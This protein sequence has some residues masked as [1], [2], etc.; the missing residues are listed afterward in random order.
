MTS[1]DCERICWNDCSCA[2]YSSATKNGIGCKTYAK[3]IY[4][5]KEADQ[6]MRYFPIVHIGKKKRIWIVVVVIGSLAPLVWLS[7]YLVYKKLHVRGKGKKIQE[8]LLYQLRRFYNYVRTD[9]KM[10]TELHY[11]TFQSISSATNGFSTTNK[12]GEGGFGAVYKGKLAD[13]QEVAVKRLSRSS[14][15]GVKEFKNETELIAK[16][17]HVNLVRLIGC[18][19]EKQEKILVYEYMPN[20][21]LDF[22]LFDP[23]KKGLLN[24][25]SRFIIID[26]IA[27]GLLYLH[28]FSRLRVI[29]RDLKASNILLDDYL[30]PKISDFGMAKLFGIN[31]SQANTSRVVGTRG[32]MPPEYL[33]DGTISTKI[34]VFGFGV[35][36]IEIAWELW[37]EGRG[38]ELMDPVLEDSSTPKEV[39]TC[40]HVGLLC[41]QDSAADRPT[42]SE[43]I[44]M[45]TNGNMHLP[46]P[47]QPAFFIQRHD[48]ETHFSGEQVNQR[49]WVANRNNPIP[50]IYGK[51]MIDVH[52]EL[53]I[54][55][56]EATVLDLFS[57]D[58]LVIRN[59]SARLLDSGNFVLQELYPDGSAKRVLWQSFDY[60]T[61]TLLPGMKLGIN[62]KTGHRWSLTSWRSHELP[63][64]GS[65][66]L[67]VDSNNGTDQVVFLRRGNIYWKS[68]P[69][70]D[71]RFVNLNQSSDPDEHSYY[72]SNETEISFSYL[73]KTYN[74]FPYVRIY[75]D[76]MYSGKSGFKLKCQSV[77]DPPGCT[78]VE[79]EKLKC[80]KGYYISETY[81]Y[82]FEEEY[83]YDESYNLSLYDC[84]RICW[85][86]C[87]CVAYTYATRN[88]VGCKTY[89]K[90]RYNPAEADRDTK[91]FAIMFL[92]E[93]RKMWNRRKLIWLIIGIG[94]LAPALLSCYLVDKKLH[95][96]GKAMKIQKQ[97]LHQLTGFYNAVPT[98]MKMKSEVH[99]FTFQSISSA[100]DSFSS[101]NKLGEGGFGEVYKGILVDGQEVAVKRLSRNSGQG[102]KE[103][104]NEIEL[105]AKLQHT[106]LV[107]L[108]G[109]C[110]EKEEKI[111]VY[112]LMPNSSLDSFLFDPRK[113]GLLKWKKR[114]L[115]ID[116]IAQGLVYLHKFSRLRV[117]HRDLKANNILL[118]ADLNPK[119]SDFGMAKLFGQNDS[120]AKTS[121][122]VGTRGYMPPEYMMEGNVS[123]KTDVFGFGVLL[124]EIVSGKINHGSYDL[125][126]PL[127]LPGHAWE[128][129]NEG[130]GLELMDPIL[131][132]SCSRIEVMKCIH[133]GLLCV[134][135]HEADRPT[136]S[137]VIYMLTNVNMELP[138]PKRPAFYIERHEA[139]EARVKDLGNG[140]V[141]G[142]SV[143]VLVAR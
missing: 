143:S 136:M 121:R 9:K 59:A 57:P 113:K 30:K 61:D 38:L 120:G 93:E 126:H 51:L 49:L 89:S 11:F 3:M 12:L 60:P 32:Y 71:G 43:V 36:L 111:L 88:L 50:D 42:M 110:F 103:F 7:C 94:S 114:F 39:M 40:I 26:G 22:F 69:W 129:W 99:Y 18:C 27:Q 58:S 105:I 90:M 67:A 102:V 95:V 137:E 28:K 86:N 98:D 45:L 91:Y 23:R 109:C 132:D 92:E 87:S 8:L 112:E 106:N 33:I 10:N 4:N 142:Q 124:L 54:L 134:Q 141:N 139:E 75:P 53:R 31:E 119:I 41:V 130:R 68:G 1:Y 24:W 55:S 74:S 133:V 125:E 37:N 140:S 122:I 79:F 80:R 73:T 20:N 15:Q 14:A 81:G 78:E 46:E 127:N 123:T 84:K 135:D 6:E 25:N 131:E 63:A 100:T 19:I 76:G 52:G 107:K 56:G 82:V 65:F 70:Q 96:R 62:L 138:E 116:G 16:L 5:P 72:I 128:L 117:I 17:Q 13:G 101:T 104:K 115:I 2:A 34:D 29:H 47:K 35:L 77:N 97:S 44:S 85:S 66:T 64:N 21:S 108:L 48:A 83:I 118:D